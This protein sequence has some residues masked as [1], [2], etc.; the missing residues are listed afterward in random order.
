MC[1]VRLE[2]LFTELHL[3]VVSGKKTQPGLLLVNVVD[4]YECYVD[5]IFSFILPSTFIVVPSKY[6]VKMW[7]Y[8][9]KKCF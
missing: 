9:V 2:Y 1:T 3:I 8:N 7:F 4:D 6:V 5:A